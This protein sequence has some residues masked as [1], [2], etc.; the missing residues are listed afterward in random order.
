MYMTIFKWFLHNYPIVHNPR[1]DWHARHFPVWTEGNGGTSAGVFGVTQS[2]FPTAFHNRIWC[3]FTTSFWEIQ[4]WLLGAI[5][6]FFYLDSSSSSFGSPC[7]WVVVIL[8]VSGFTSTQ[9]N[10]LG[11]FFNRGNFWTTSAGD[12]HQGYLTGY[13]ELC[14]IYCMEIQKRVVVGLERIESLIACMVKIFYQNPIAREWLH[15]VEPLTKWIPME[16]RN[17]RIQEVVFY[18]VALQD[19]VY[20]AVDEG[21]LTDTWVQGTLQRCP[22]RKRYS[23]LMLAVLR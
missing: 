16:A 20:L 1:P 6:V 17:L 2:F 19:I 14:F 4:W 12:H 10:P 23:L 8:E 7:V 22:P 13:Y 15:N 21:H 3:S 18:F 11:V 9:I 5:F